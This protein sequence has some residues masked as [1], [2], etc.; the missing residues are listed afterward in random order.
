MAAPA[1]RPLPVVAVGVAGV[2]GDRTGVLRAGRAGPEPNGSAGAASSGLG[3]AT[4]ADVTQGIV[5]AEEETGT[6]VSGAVESSG[7]VDDIGFAGTAGAG[8]V[9]IV[10][11]VG[12]VGTAGAAGPAGG[13]KGG[14]AMAVVATA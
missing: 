14:G 2:A 7:P 10:E 11:T 13:T 3:D 5:G 9:W 12:A 1:F 4:E 8:A 6:P